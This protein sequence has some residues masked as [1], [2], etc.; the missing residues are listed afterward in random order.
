VTISADQEQPGGGIAPPR[1]IVPHA[2]PVRAAAP[3]AP[4]SLS[5]QAIP[6]TPAAPMRTA[7]LAPTAPRT[8]A[9]GGHGYYVQVSAQKTQEE[10]RASYRGIQTKYASIL[11]GHAPVF[12]RKDL[13]SRGVFYGAQVGPF[14]HEAAV[15]LCEQ[16][17]SAGGSC[18][19]QRN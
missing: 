15:H 13:G 2:P 1:Q 9:A 11:H 16:L 14:S 4:L 17:K 18:M 5:P 10:A 3:N 6:D 7:A 12:R 19:I 8:E